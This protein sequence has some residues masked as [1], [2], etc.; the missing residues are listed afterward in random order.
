[1]PCNSREEVE[2]AARALD[3]HFGAARAAAAATGMFLSWASDVDLMEWGYHD[4]H[5]H[6]DFKY[7]YFKI[8]AEVGIVGKG[9]ETLEFTQGMCT[10]FYVF[11]KP[12]NSSQSQTGSSSP[13]SYNESPTIMADMHKI[14]G[15]FLARSVKL[16][17]E[18][19]VDS[20]RISEKELNRGGSWGWHIWFALI[21]GIGA[22]IFI[23]VCVVAVVVVLCKRRQNQN[24]LAVSTRPTSSV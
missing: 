21:V 13:P 7:S 8:L 22:A 6:P 1:M 19:S 3:R 12:I 16:C 15:L 10:Y 11:P 17:D 18:K 5:D 2:D 9:C 24:N 14:D 4:N 20:C 23:I